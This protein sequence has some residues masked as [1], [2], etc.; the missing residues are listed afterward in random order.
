MTEGINNVVLKDGEL[1]VEV[2]DVQRPPDRSP[3]LGSPGL[4][5]CHSSN[6]LRGGGVVLFPQ[7]AR[8]LCLILSYFPVC[9][10]TR[11][12]WVGDIVKERKK[13]FL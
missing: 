5:W 2:V 13:R 3:T 1:V 7:F 4:L 8:V 6:E 9:S 12:D 10:F 11:R